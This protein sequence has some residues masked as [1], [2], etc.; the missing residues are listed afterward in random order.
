MEQTNPQKGQNLAFSLDGAA[1]LSLR[2]VAKTFADKTVLDL[3]Q[4]DIQPSEIRALL[5]QN[6]SGKSTLIKVLSGYHHLAYGRGYETRFGTIRRRAARRDALAALERVGLEVDPRTVVAALTPSQ[7]TAVAV[8]RA[9]DLSGGVQPRLLVL[10]EPTATLPDEEVASLLATM[11]RTAAAGVAII[12]VTH[13]LDEA[14]EISDRIS[15]LRGGKLIGTEPATID[16]DSLV[17]MLVGEELEQAYRDEARR[18]R[19]LDVTAAPRLV[20]DRLEADHLKPISFSVRPG[21]VLGVY[22][23]TGSGREAILGATFGALPRVGGEVKIGG[24]SIPPGNPRIAI[25][26]GAG[27]MAPDRKTHGGMMQSSAREN[28]TIVDPWRFWTAFGLRK[29]LER[30]EALAWFDRVAVSPSGAVEAPLASFSG[31]NQQKILFAKWLRQNPGVLLMDEPTQG[32]DIGARAILHG[33]ILE[34]AEAGTA[35]VVSST[36]E[37]E[38]AAICSRILVIANGEIA[39]ELGK[40]AITE[41]AIVTS[42]HSN[43]KKAGEGVK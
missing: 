22:G 37:E 13:H 17:E 42:M 38:L 29:R 2:N 10:D 34:A 15:V 23:L 12:F 1:T 7:Q 26:A 5:G 40:E 32:V 14:F 24:R 30:K 25:Q 28:L 43:G 39:A 11:R 4:L 18:A 20:V 36:D 3:E 6:G 35:V 9:I 8:A 16:R 31:G 41:Q 27:Y 21:E 33:Q 19:E